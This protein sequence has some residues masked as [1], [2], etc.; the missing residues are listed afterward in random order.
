MTTGYVTG[1]FYAI[2]S[3]SGLVGKIITSMQI[4]PVNPCTTNPRDV[5]RIETTVSLRNQE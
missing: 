2:P 4:C 1:N 3:A 5:V